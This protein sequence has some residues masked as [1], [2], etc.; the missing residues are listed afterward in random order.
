MSDASVKL[1]IM[2]LCINLVLMLDGFASGTYNDGSTLDLVNSSYNQGGL[3]GSDDVGGLL[4][5][6]GPIKDFFL[7]G[8]IYGMLVAA[9]LPR[10]IQYVIGAPMAALGFF[11][12]LPILKSVGSGV[13]G[14]IGR[15]VG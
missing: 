11:A 8:G 10:Q 15:L 5:S 9:G 3:S 2:F 12:L 14:I 1:Y 7:G 6:I 13:A 4:D